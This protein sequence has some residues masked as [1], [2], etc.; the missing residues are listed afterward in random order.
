MFPLKAPLLSTQRWAGS[1]YS[2]AGGQN[3]NFGSL[4][5]LYLSLKIY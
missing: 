5:G 4:V 1:G 2:R 3:P